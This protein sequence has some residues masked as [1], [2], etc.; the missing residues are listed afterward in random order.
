MKFL[1]NKNSP[2]SVSKNKKSSDEVKMNLQNITDGSP[3]N[4]KDSDKRTFLKILGLAGLG[5][6]ASSAFPKKADALIIGN[7]ST[8]GVIGL[9]NA[10]NVRINPAT[11]DGNLATI[12][13]TVAKETGGNLATL[14]GKDFAKESGGHLASIDTST[15]T[16][17]TNTTPLT[18]LQFDGS[19][20]LKVVT[21]GGGSGGGAIQVEDSTQKIINPSTE[22]SEVYLRRMV[23]LLETLATV[24]LANRQRISLDTI[25]AGVTLPTVTT[26]TTVGTVSTIT[27]GTIT[28]ITNP[29][30]VGNI[31]T[32]SG[33]DREQY[34]NIAKNA[35]ANGIRSN[36]TWS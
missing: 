33:M 27:G 19:N 7:Q 13:S 5:I 32:I 28:T 31:A 1:P 8:S 9:K 11:E 26:V 25:P 12:A 23:R 2:K 4:V 3:A 14:A 15:T 22:D 18:N 10:S 24:D 17:A 30:P 16:I 29:V 20:N 35:W 36:L 21:T 34:I 6:L